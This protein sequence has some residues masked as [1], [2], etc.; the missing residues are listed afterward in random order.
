MD[1]K[2]TY[3]VHI[4]F[5]EQV[6]KVSS[7]RDRIAN[8][9]EDTTCGGCSAFRVTSVLESIFTHAQLAYL[10]AH[11][12]AE[13][14]LLD[15]NQAMPEYDLCECGEKRGD[16]GSVSNDHEFFLLFAAKPPAGFRKVVG[17][18]P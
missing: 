15:V 13:V 12:D 16:H 11:P 2:E 8:S 3:K 17:G 5:P 9:F 6:R 14:V 18:E 4:G 1:N 10:E 7:L